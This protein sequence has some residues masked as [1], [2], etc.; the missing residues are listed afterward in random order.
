VGIAGA[1]SQPSHRSIFMFYIPAFH[2]VLFEYQLLSLP[3]LI[4]TQTVKCLILHYEV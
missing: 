2:T 1:P 3:H 4:E